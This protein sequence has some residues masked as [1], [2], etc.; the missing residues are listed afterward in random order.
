[1]MAILAGCILEVGDD[2]DEWFVCALW[3]LLLIGGLFYL[4]YRVAKK[5]AKK[6]RKSL[7]L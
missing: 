5:I 6:I 3:P 1:M 4:W 7:N 2:E